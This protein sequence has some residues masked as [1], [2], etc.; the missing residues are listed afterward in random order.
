M[1]GKSWIK[2]DP[3]Y[4]HEMKHYCNLC[5][6]ELVVKKIKK[7]VNSKSPEAKNFNF[8]IIGD[9]IMIGDVEFIF[10]VFFCPKCNIEITIN[11]QIR[12]ECEKNKEYNRWQIIP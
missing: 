6:G 9:S 5:D 7:I 10:E 4:V 3:Y 11:E 12:F 1:N 2:H 8:S